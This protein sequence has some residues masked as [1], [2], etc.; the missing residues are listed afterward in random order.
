M[1]LTKHKKNR[2][3]IRRGAKNRNHS[4]KQKGGAISTISDLNKVIPTLQKLHLNY[5]TNH[6][7]KLGV[8]FIMSKSNELLVILKTI[9]DDAQLVQ[10]L[11]DPYNPKTEA[12]RKV[13]NVLLPE[14]SPRHGDPLE[15]KAYL[16]ELNDIHKKINQINQ[17]SGDK[18]KVH[19]I[20][21]MKDLS[22]FN[23][24]TG[25]IL[26][27]FESYDTTDT[28]KFRI[29]KINKFNDEIIA[30]F[31]N[32]KAQCENDDHYR[33]NLIG[34]ALDKA[35]AIAKSKVFQFISM[36][37]ELEA[38]FYEENTN[39]TLFN[40]SNLAVNAVMDAV[41]LKFN[42]YKL[43]LSMTE[44]MNTFSD[45]NKNNF[46]TVEILINLL[47]ALK[48]PKLDDDYLKSIN[49]YKHIIFDLNVRIIYI[50][51]W[52]F[53]NKEIAITYI[54]DLIK[55]IH[56]HISILKTNKAFILY[57]STLSLSFIDNLNKILKI[58][59]TV[60]QQLEPSRPRSA[61]RSAPA[62]PSLHEPVHGHGHGS[63]SRNGSRRGNAARLQHNAR[64]VRRSGAFSPVNAKYLNRNSGSQHN[65]DNLERNT[66]QESNWVDLPLQPQNGFASGLDEA[67][68]RNVDLITFPNDI[69]HILQ[70]LD[71]GN[72]S[73]APH[74]QMHASASVLASPATHRSATVADHPVTPNR[75][76]NTVRHPAPAASSLAS[77]SASSHRDES[78][79]RAPYASAPRNQH[80]PPTASKV[81]SNTVISLIDNTLEAA[82]NLLQMHS[83]LSNTV[84]K[85]TL[86]KLIQNA[87]FITDQFGTNPKYS[88]KIQKINKLIRALQQIE[89]TKAQ[90]YDSY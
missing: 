55:L 64:N 5:P 52:Y 77:L 37:N 86:N 88:A 32:I 12:I 62:S 81:N 87:A 75:T 43:I 31:R 51:N 68:H 13:L 66:S 15:I 35:E 21:L 26:E 83:K 49:L 50:Y 3:S 78:H 22:I 25:K 61:P 16:K 80:N 44:F 59:E 36:Y 24:R 17:I 29:K 45:L 9:K 57:N 63:A 72:N 76:N 65:I 69:R 82:N 39:N 74:A 2:R 28:T 33:L 8:Q 38:K 58:L 71:S 6:N 79:N 4:K 11:N 73:A 60:T 42:F 1:K 19:C 89:L 34:K 54:D 90:V 70:N 14:F 85:D 27:I 84:F 47:D 10:I 40:N 41:I 18:I 53:S 67:S 46:K 23:D 20:D 30:L 56:S 48:L 7:D